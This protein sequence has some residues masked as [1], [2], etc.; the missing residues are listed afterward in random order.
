MENIV[1][2]WHCSSQSSAA[3]T[4]TDVSC[5]CGTGILMWPELCNT[6][7]SLG[8]SSQGSPQPSPGI[9]LQQHLALV[10]L[11]ALGTEHF[12]FSKFVKQKLWR[13]SSQ[14]S[15]HHRPPYWSW[16]RTECSMSNC[17]WRNSSPRLN[18]GHRLDSQLKDRSGKP[19]WPVSH[20]HLHWPV[21]KVWCNYLKCLKWFYNVPR[22]L[23]KLCSV[24]KWFPCLF[25]YC[26]T[27]A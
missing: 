10:V 16:R 1:C 11:K 13:V 2:A 25:F 8:H 4:G 18:T 5:P 14:E 21:Y 26:Y 7:S 15:R 19:P 3:V 17:F 24:L 23:E 27:I 9:L 6:S 20:A 22:K 12:P